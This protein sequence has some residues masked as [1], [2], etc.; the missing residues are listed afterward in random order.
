MSDATEPQVPPQELRDLLVS[1]PAFVN[2]VLPWNYADVGNWS[3]LQIGYRIHG[4]SG[5]SLVSEQP[6]D[7]HPEWWVFAT[8]YFADPFI[9]DLR[10]SHAGFPVRFASVGAG[11]WAPILVADSAAEFIGWLERLAQIESQPDAAA[12]FIEAELPRNGF[13]DE[14]AATYREDDE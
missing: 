4:L 6:G 3:E 5:E 2:M 9:V 12:S 7:W 11:R 14:V 8:N 1:S 13:W 10:E